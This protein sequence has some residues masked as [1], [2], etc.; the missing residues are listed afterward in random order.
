MREQA[1]TNHFKS[2]LSHFLV[3]Y[4]GAA[5]CLSVRRQTVPLGQPVRFR[6]ILGGTL[7]SVPAASHLSTGGFAAAAAIIRVA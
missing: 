4:P 3:G 6:R 1:Q 2:G 7:S 5:L